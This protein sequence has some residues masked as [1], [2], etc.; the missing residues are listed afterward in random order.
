MF[1]DVSLDSRQCHS[2]LSK[3]PAKNADLEEF[4]ESFAEK[5]AKRRRH[6]AI[7]RSDS[8]ECIREQLSTTAVSIYSLMIWQ[9]F[10]TSACV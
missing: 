7:V 2:E 3:D 8:P 5:L 1:C 10:A 6:C 9:A 4:G